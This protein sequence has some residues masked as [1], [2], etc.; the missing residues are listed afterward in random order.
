M[1]LQQIPKMEIPKTVVGG[2]EYYL[3]ENMYI[4][5]EFK[6]YIVL[7]ELIKRGFKLKL[8]YDRIG[9]DVRGQPDKFSMDPENG[10]APMLPLKVEVFK[11][12]VSLVQDGLSSIFGLKVERTDR[13]IAE[14]NNL[15]GLDPEPMESLS[16]ILLD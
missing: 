13:Q 8:Y 6:W 5:L 2:K 7:K 9:N 16:L 10:I 15:R 4:P 11:E 3:Y 12:S 1:E 14:I